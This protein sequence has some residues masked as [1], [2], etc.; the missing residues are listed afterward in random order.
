MNAKMALTIGIQK[1]RSLDSTLDNRLVALYKLQ[2][3]TNLSFFSRFHFIT[4]LFK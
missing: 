3:T 2:R 4:F 1:I